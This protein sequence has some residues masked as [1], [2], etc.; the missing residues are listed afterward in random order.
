MPL[1]GV[2]PGRQERREAVARFYAELVG[3]CAPSEPDSRQPR[4]D[5]APAAG[6][7]AAAGASVYVPRGMRRGGV[8]REDADSAVRAGWEKVGGEGVL[9]K[10]PP[11]KRRRRG[12]GVD[13]IGAVGRREDLAREKAELPA[14]FGAAERHRHAIDK[15]NVGYE[16]LRGMGWKEGEGL[17]VERQGTVEPLKARAN[18]GR[19]GIG[20]HGDASR[21]RRL[22]GAAKEDEGR[23]SQ[24]GG[25]GSKRVTARE[26]AKQVLAEEAA[27]ESVE[28]KVRRH[29]QVMD[30]EAVEQ[31]G[32][33]IQRLL[34]TQLREPDP[35]CGADANPLTRR[36]RGR[37]GGV[38]DANPL[39]GFWD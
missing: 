4:E 8:Q 34:Y 1:R 19:K 28:D 37:R 10:Q 33:A 36:G 38:S 18:K 15:G 5:A 27:K 23:A 9:V 21:K 22:A 16:M 17:G 3:V 30:A 13:D 32:K 20:L 11:A 29:K 26:R 2:E 39:A 25:E 12:D 31:R 24:K 35:G 14:A 7:E 6:A